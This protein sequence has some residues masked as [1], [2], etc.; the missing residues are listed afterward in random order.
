MFEW[1]LFFLVDEHA[2]KRYCMNDQ[3]E[4][5]LAI[6][7][8]APKTPENFFWRSVAEYKLNHKEEATAQLKN[9]LTPMKPHNPPLPERYLVVAEM[10]QTELNDRWTKDELDNTARKMDNVSRRLNIGM[11]KGDTQKLQK[12]I[13][14]D[15]DKKIKEA[16]DE[17]AKA[18]ASASGSGSNNVQRH[19]G[20]SKIME[21]AG[22]GNVEN[23]KLVITNEVWGKM[24]AKEKVKALEAINKQLPPHIREAA[25]GFSKKLQNGGR[26]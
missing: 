16:E 23:K 22:E 14:D 3:Y 17:I 25:E 5:A 12:E 21:G 9:V 8:L 6:A 2:M 11:A 18:T 10:M 7:K 13:I 1:I 20:D 15:L 24:P 19:A 4:K 26:P